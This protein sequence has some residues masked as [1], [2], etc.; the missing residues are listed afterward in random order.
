MSDSKKSYTDMNS[1]SYS[2]RDRKNQNL[3]LLNSVRVKKEENLYK[4]CVSNDGMYKLTVPVSLKKY[5]R[6]SIQQV[7][8]EI[9]NEN[10][11]GENPTKFL[12]MSQKKLNL[13]TDN[14]N[15]YLFD[16]HSTYKITFDKNSTTVTDIG[17]SDFSFIDVRKS[18]DS[19]LARS[20]S[21][22]EER[23]RDSLKHILPVIYQY[24]RMMRSPGSISDINPR[25]AA[26]S[27]IL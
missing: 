25:N 5:K 9:S 16:D 21:N 11:Y 18:Y 27:V 12:K 6:F 26:V 19:K 1:L 3:S 17:D 10:A 15:E 7:R 23:K 24:K 4:D 20:T 8:D 2:K 14:N 22:D 13:N